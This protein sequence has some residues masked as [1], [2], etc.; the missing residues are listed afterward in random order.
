MTP[1]RRL[2]VAAAAAAL[3][4]GVAAM[5]AGPALAQPAQ[6]PIGPKQYFAGQ[7]N[8]NIGQ[9]VLSVRG[10]APATTAAAAPG[11]G[12]PLPGQT[13][14]VREFVVPPPS[15]GPTF[16]GYTGRA[17]KVSV[18]LVVEM[19][20]PPLAYQVHLANLTAYGQT[21]AIPTTLS[22]P[23]NAVVTAVFNPLNGGAKERVSDVN[24][25]VETP[26][27]VAVAPTPISVSSAPIYLLQG[28][29]FVPNTGY[30]VV[31]CPSTNW[32]VPQNPCVTSNS[33]NVTTDD[34]G[35]FTHSFVP[36]PCTV[37]VPSTC[38]VGV[39]IPTGIDTI[40]LVGADKIIVP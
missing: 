27:I 18:D 23:C 1:F 17:H 38:Y 16:L 25:T 39:A 9:S 29:G 21:A 26:H 2:L 20:E 36:V 10:C 32:I 30:T 5:V 15:V 11:K 4:T 22:I 19:V 24:V 31:E 8:G 6:Q 37:V 3:T 13:V 40:T 34:N 33:V 28:T 14:S 35:A 12:N 7:V